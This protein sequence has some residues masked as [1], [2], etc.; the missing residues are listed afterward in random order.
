[1]S[2][3]YSL[4]YCRDAVPTRTQYML[5]KSKPRMSGGLWGPFNGD[6]VAAQPT[7]IGGLDI[8]LGAGPIPVRLVREE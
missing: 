2:D 7:P 5:F 6:V 3:E 4:Y 1:M 8:P